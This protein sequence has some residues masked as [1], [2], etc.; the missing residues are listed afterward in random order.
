MGHRLWKR[1][2]ECSELTLDSACLELEV[3][4]Q[5]RLVRNR[6]RQFSLLPWSP[7]RC[8]GRVCDTLL[9]LIYGRSEAGSR[10]FPLE[11]SDVLKDLGHGPSIVF[12]SLRRIRRYEINCSCD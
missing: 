5:R 10:W 12:G 3:G 7:K 6:R 9:E 2:F 4:N 11:G 1:R 8:V